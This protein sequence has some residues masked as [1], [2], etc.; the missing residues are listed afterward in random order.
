M[1][2]N[3]SG[4]YVVRGQVTESGGPMRINLFDGT[5]KSGFRVVNFTIAAEETNAT[6]ETQAKV[7]TEISQYDGNIWHWEIPT[8]IAWASTNM[9]ADGAREPPFQAVDSSVV[10]VEDLFVY[11]HNNTSASFRVNFMIELQPVSLLEFEYAMSFI[12]N[13]S[14]G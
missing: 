1:R 9:F 7:T 11:G 12:Q 6:S 14:Q 3:R 5:Y 10:V 13:K 8:E 4:N 2:V